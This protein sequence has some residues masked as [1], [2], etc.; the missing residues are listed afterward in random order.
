M[1]GSEA[2]A[3]KDI[4]RMMRLLRW[5]DGWSEILCVHGKLSREEWTHQIL[6]TTQHLH[7]YYVQ[8]TDLYAIS[9]GPKC[10]QIMQGMIQWFYFS[11]FSIFKRVHARKGYEQIA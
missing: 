5:M 2:M 10:L 8:I 6:S 11:P 7:L 1:Q 9:L 4:E 3:E